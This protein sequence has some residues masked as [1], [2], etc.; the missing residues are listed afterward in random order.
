MK[1]RVTGNPRGFGFVSFVDPS[2][3]DVAIH[4]SSSK[5]SILGRPVSAIKTMAKLFPYF[6]SNYS[7]F[8]GRRE[9]SKTKMRSNSDAEQRTTFPG[10]RRFGFRPRQH[11]EDL[12]RGSLRELN[13][14][15]VPEL[16]REI[17]EDHR[18]RR[19]SIS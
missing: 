17:R 18:R 14:G 1:D 8:L 19:Y 4:D 15:R 16:F 7:F 11:E 2:S 12:R 6:F 13:E 10:D 5:H 3:A 9:E